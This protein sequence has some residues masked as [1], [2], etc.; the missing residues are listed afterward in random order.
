MIDRSFLKEGRF[1]VVV[2]LQFGDRGD[3]PEI[4]LWDVVVIE[5]KILLQGG[6]QVTGGG[7]RGGFQHFGDAAVEAFD[8]AVGLRVAGFDRA[9]VD[10]VR[11]AGLIEGVP[12]GRLA[13]AGGAEAVGE[14]LA[15]VGEDGPHEERRFGVQA[16]QEAGGGVG[17]FVRLDLEIHPAAGPVDGRKQI[18]MFG[19]SRHPGQVFDAHL[20]KSGPVALEGLGQGGL[21]F[22]LRQQVGQ[23]GHAVTAQTPIRR[24]ARQVRADELAGHHQQV[25]QRQ[26]QEFA[27]L[28]HHELLHRV[29]GRGQPARRVRP[30]L[31]RVPSPPAPDGGLAHPQFH[32]QF[33]RQFGR[34]SGRG[35]Q[36]RP[37]LGR[38]GGVGVRANLHQG[39]RSAWVRS[40]KN[41]RGSSRRRLRVST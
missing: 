32:P 15:V 21:A 36:I 38:G 22:R 1:G 23:P 10:A 17:R 2:L 11:G 39:L 12:A 37:L 31:H 5:V 8:H 20:H 29:Q 30:V 4:L 14:L 41:R 3:M 33:H 16:L 18:A 35:L 19:F 24:R 25:V 7:E 9:V 27:Q 28:D 34:R 13:L 40:C 26:P 6:F